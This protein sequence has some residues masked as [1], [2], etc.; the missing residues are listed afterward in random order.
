MTA[1]GDLIPP[2]VTLDHEQ[3]GSA[4]VVHLVGD[5]SR[6]E[7]LRLHDALFDVG[8]EAGQVV[9]DMTG[10]EF[11]SASGIG[12]LVELHRHLV[13]HGRA[14]VLAHVNP[15]VRDLLRL[16]NVDTILPVWDSVDAV[17]AAEAAV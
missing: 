7:A 14:V 11:I 9:L 10:V 13:D 12:L 6:R 1:F 15:L 5:L 2:P 17:I 16:T 3:V 8:H 4:H